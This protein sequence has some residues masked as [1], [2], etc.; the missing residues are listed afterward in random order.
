ME[1][2]SKIVCCNFQKAAQSK[3]TPKRQKIAQSGHA[4]QS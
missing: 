1:K 3:L 4:A 2:I